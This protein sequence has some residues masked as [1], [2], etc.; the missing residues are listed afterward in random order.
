MGKKKKE[1]LLSNAQAAKKELTLAEEDLAKLLHDLQ[2]AANGQK[3]AFGAA[4]EAAFNRLGAA[5]KYLVAVEKLAKK[6]DK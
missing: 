2:D 3:T 1:K 5:R 4:M 6:D